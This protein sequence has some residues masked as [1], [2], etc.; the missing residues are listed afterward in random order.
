MGVSA[1]EPV[2]DHDDIFGAAVQLAARVC[3]TASAE[4][5]LASRV[6]GDLCIGKPFEF[7]DFGHADLKG[8]EQPVQLLE[9][10]WVD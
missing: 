8:F 9:V 7:R 3:A 4:Q 5:I 10:A 1:G 2:S 6:I